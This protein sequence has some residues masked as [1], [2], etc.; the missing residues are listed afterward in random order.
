MLQ[1]LKFN[2]PDYDHRFEILNGDL[3]QRFTWWRWYPDCDTFFQL[4]DLGCNGSSPTISDVLQ[5]VGSHATLWLDTWQGTIAPMDVQPTGWTYPSGKD[6]EPEW[7]WRW[8]PS[9]L[10]ETH[11]VNYLNM[12]VIDAWSVDCPFKCG[13]PFQTQRSLGEVR[14]IDAIPLMRLPD[15]VRKDTEWIFEFNPATRRENAF[16]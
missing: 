10:T 3:S 2:T 7:W 4:Q 11:A 12:N 5:L 13:I 15:M 9:D 16:T 8:Y 14:K 1:R 6:L